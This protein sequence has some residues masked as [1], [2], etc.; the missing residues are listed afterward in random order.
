MSNLEAQSEQT[1]DQLVQAFERCEHKIHNSM[2]RIFIE[3]NACSQLSHNSI[4]I[5]Q[6][7]H[8]KK[9]IYLCPVQVM[10]NPRAA[11]RR[12]C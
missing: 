8:K 5:R 6:E 11:G 7:Q 2:E 1:T 3:H 12:L 10:L 9:E 4:C